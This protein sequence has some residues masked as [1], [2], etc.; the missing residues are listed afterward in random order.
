M[1]NEFTFGNVATKVLKDVNDTFE[2]FYDDYNQ[3][4]FSK[5]EHEQKGTLETTFKYHYCI[6]VT[7]MG[8]AGCY[9]SDKEYN[10]CSKYIIEL[11]VVPTF[12]S[13]CE[14]KQKSI[15]SQFSEEDFVLYCTG[16]KKSL[17]MDI[18]MYGYSIRMLEES[19]DTEEELEKKN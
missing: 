9:D 17:L 19:A 18:Q 16:D 4:W 13:L 1:S 14:E 6:S 12:D 7:D 3:L 15:S 5:E 10:D 11:Q 2:N 8:E